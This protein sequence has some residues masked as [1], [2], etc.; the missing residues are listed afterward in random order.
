MEVIYPSNATT[1]GQPPRFTS[2]Y[3]FLTSNSKRLLAV[4]FTSVAV[5]LLMMLAT[6]KILAAKVNDQC[7]SAGWQHIRQHHN[8]PWELWL[9]T[10]YVVSVVHALILITVGVLLGPVKKGFLI[11]F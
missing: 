11:S 7:A 10:S 3:D 8:K 6:K 2:H 9:L 5:F 1:L 4:Y